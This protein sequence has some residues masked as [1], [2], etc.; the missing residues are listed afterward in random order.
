MSARVVYL[1]RA[2]AGGILRTVRVVGER[3][4]ESWDATIGDV[5]D[6]IDAID[7]ARAAS[8]W[9]HERLKAGSATRQATLVA[10]VDGA[11]CSWLTVPSPDASVVA[12]AMEHS[13]S[14]PLGE[15]GLIPMGVTSAGTSVQAI[16]AATSDIAGDRRAIL[17]VPDAIVRIVLDE[18][19]AI[20]VV[21][22]AV[23]S[24]WHAISIAWD[25]SASTDAGT[26]QDRVVAE[27]AQTTGIVLID[28]HGTLMW[29][30]TTGGRLLTCG[31]QR[32]EV[33]GDGVC[34]EA[35]DI[36][37]LISDWLSWSLQNGSSP[38]RIVCVVPRLDSAGLSAAQIGERLGN[39]WP[40]ASI[41]MGVVEAPAQETLERLAAAQKLKTESMAALAG[42]PGRAHRRM[43][44]AMA[45]AALAIGL[46]LG[47]HGWSMRQTAQDARAEIENVKDAT[48]LRAQEVIPD[49]ER[50]GILE[51]VNAEFRRMQGSGPE[52]EI[53]PVMP[54]LEE[55][56]NIAF[57]LS[58]T[59]V[60]WRNL[61]L[62]SGP[63][64]PL[65]TLQAYFED[66]DIESMDLLER[67]LNALRVHLSG[68]DRGD[69]RPIGRRVRTSYQSRWILDEEDSQ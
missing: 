44:L 31:R 24:M 18:L 4:T 65:A 35:Q 21:P 22:Q 12:A 25:P 10:D 13:E 51:R 38:S 15:H 47:M 52:G 9:I 58:T 63:L 36:S 56:E 1:G 66:G 32:L 37:R 7:Q 34:V 6:P 61:E 42:R 23:L 54:I 39:A 60:E 64:L 3:T 2:A 8:K 55:L 30:W 49:I 46:L 40:G 17:C 68:W 41:D 62:R 19:D 45:G 53:E 59:G 28:E 50:R 14:S 48:Y 69:S 20:G 16:G 5:V 27:S 29:S 57:A 67:Q 33:I 43:H 26:R 11:S